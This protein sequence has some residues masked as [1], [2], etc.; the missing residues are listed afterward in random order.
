MLRAQDWFD[1]AVEELRA[2]RDLRTT[3]HYSWACFTCQQAAEK[4]LKALAERLTRALPTGHN[5]NDLLSDIEAYQPVSA[6]VRDA[7]RRLN[8]LYIPT[9]YP[10]AFPSGVPAH[11]YA[12]DDADQAIA[13][14][15]E[16]IDF[17]RRHL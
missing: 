9:R 11:Q 2:A 15:E 8:R 7:S 6:T 3:G 17:V 13:D 5:L 12:E 10:D 14:A 1:E 4:A 16:V